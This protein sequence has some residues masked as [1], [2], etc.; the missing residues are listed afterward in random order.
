MR[1]ERAESTAL[2]LTQK[3]IEICTESGRELFAW[4]SGLGATSFLWSPDSS[5]LAVN[6]MPGES[7]DLVRLFHLDPQASVVTPLREP[8]G[9]KLLDEEEARHGSFLSSVDEVHLRAIEWREGHLWCLLTGSCHP[10][11][12]PTV[13]VPFHHLWVFGVNGKEVPSFLQEWT[14]TD[15]RETPVRDPVP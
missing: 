2:G 1:R 8:D 7:G 4:I 3:R 6:D 10:K 13:H 15:P 5:Y 9:K 14:L 12:E 11:R